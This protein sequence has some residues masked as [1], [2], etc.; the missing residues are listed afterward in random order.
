MKKVA[1]PILTVE[2][3]AS[4][5]NKAEIK[6]TGFKMTMVSSEKGRTMIEAQRDSRRQR[7]IA[8]VNESHKF[9]DQFY[10]NFCERKNEIKERSRIFVAASDQEIGDIMGGLTDELLLE[11]EIAYVNAIWDKVSQH[12]SARLADSEQLRA[13]LDQLQVFQQKGSTGFLNKLRDDLINIAFLLEPQVDELL[14]EYRVK[15]EKRYELE[16]AE[17]DVFHQD[18][19][20]TDASK[21]ESLYARWKEAV[22]QFH[23]LKQSDAIKKFLDRMNSEEFVNP[24]SR[25]AIFEE[26]REEQMTLFTQRTKVMQALDT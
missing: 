9:I 7:H 18:V 10:D 24:P 25:V 13:N 19:V 1:E 22:V 15:D 8:A 3:K 26:M 17:L 6:G 12:R 4:R 5:V 14:V 21:F 2:E 16:H 11:N 23:K 20:T